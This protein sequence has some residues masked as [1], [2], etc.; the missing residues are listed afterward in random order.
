MSKGGDGALCWTNDVITQD[1]SCIIFVFD[2][3]GNNHRYRYIGNRP[4]SAD[5]IGVPIYRSGLSENMLVIS[6]ISSVYNSEFRNI[7]LWW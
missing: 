2:I 7:S 4:I 6:K 1:N 3:G 5:N